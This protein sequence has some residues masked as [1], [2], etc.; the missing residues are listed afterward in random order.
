MKLQSRYHQVIP[1]CGCV[2]L[3][4]WTSSWWRFV[5]LVSGR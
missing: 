2:V 4:Y 5:S 3:G 1:H